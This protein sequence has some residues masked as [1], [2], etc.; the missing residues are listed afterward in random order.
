M[1]GEGD[2]KVLGVWTSPFV[3]RVRVALNLKGLPYEYVEEDLGNK[4]A[5]LLSS[6][7]VHKAVPVF[8]HGDR[9]VNESQIIVQY[10]DEVWPAGAGGRPAVLP[11]DP[12]ERAMARFWAAF[13][14]DKVGSAWTGML[15]K[16]RNEEERAEAVA[17]AQDALETLEGAFK[18][19]SNQGN[20][21]FFGGDG[22]GLVDVVLG[23]YLGWFGVVNRIIGRRLIDPARTPLLAAWEDRFRAADAVK[24]VVPEDVDRMLVFLEKLRTLGP[25]KPE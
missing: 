2:L 25:Y 11:S 14:D 10:I 23:G 6:N 19:C 18:E 17:R 7:P 3:I 21:P 1:A 16:C 24:G 9:A 20:K 12:Y 5:L 8:I 15:F 13:V 4:S 22:I